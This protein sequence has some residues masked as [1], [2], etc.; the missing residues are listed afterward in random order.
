[1]LLLPA[2]ASV[3]S[4]VGGLGPFDTPF[5]SSKT[6]HVSHLLAAAAPKLTTTVQR[7]E[8]ETLPGDALFG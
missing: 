5:E 6:A 3:S 8:L 2:A 4:V 1:V 7:L